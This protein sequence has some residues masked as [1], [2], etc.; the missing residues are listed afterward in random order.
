MPASSALISKFPLAHVLKVTDQYIAKVE[1]LIRH[2]VE[3]KDLKL[4][5]FEYRRGS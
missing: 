1:D 2:T 4:I 3:P 5:V